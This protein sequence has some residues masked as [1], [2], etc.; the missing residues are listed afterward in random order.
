MTRDQLELLF[1]VQAITLFLVGIWSWSLTEAAKLAAF[2]VI[3]LTVEL[4]INRLQRDWARPPLAKI[5]TCLLIG[6]T[7]GVGAGWGVSTWMSAS[8]AVLV[9]LGVTAV[10][11]VVVAGHQPKDRR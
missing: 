11:A 7:S 8:D 3:L 6:I 5:F 4:L 10:T 1:V 2:G 9:G